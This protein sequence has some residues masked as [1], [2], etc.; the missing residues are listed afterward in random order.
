MTFL[1]RSKLLPKLICGVFLML[2]TTVFAVTLSDAKKQGKIGEEYTG[3]IGI[4]S[5]A[6]PEITQLVTVTNQKRKAKYKEIA[7]KRKQ[8]LSTVETIAGQ[9][10]MKKTLAGNYIKPKGQGWKKK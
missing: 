9:S 5:G 4:V 7:T 8:P 2:S 10:A 3:Y 6:T 1:L